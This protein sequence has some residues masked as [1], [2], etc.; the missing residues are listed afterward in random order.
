MIHD[1]TGKFSSRWVFPDRRSLAVVIRNWLHSL[2]IGGV[3]R[4]S[5]HARRS[6]APYRGIRCQNQCYMGCLAPPVTRVIELRMA[7]PRGLTDASR[8]LLTVALEDLVAGGA[9]LGTM[10]LQTRQ[11][12]EIALVDHGTAELLHVAGAG[13]L[14]L[15]RSAALLLGEG[16]GRSRDRQQGECEEKFT[17]RIPSFRQQEILFLDLRRNRLVWMAGAPRNAATN[18]GQTW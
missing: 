8:A 14:F 18:E 12:G 16:S 9:D 10:F 2:G 4:C 1:A 6:R 5:A 17:H 15:R 13:L 11:D 7:I 3:R